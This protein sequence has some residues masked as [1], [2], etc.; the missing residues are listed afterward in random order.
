MRQLHELRPVI[1]RYARD[2]C[3]RLDYNHDYEHH[4][5]FV[6]RDAEYIAEEERADRDVVW[7]AAMLHEIGLVQGRSGHD[8]R[9]ARLAQEY[10]RG[11]G[12]ADT[13]V[14]RISIAIRENTHDRVAA[15]TLETKCL[16]D[17]DNLQTIGP[18]GFVRVLSDLL[19]VLQKLPRHE[20]M[21][22]LPKY[23]ER[24]MGRL[25]TKTGR[26]LAEQGHRLMQEFYG[27][28]EAFY[29]HV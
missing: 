9:G 28:Y 11:L 23:Q 8:E 17:A 1:Q 10:L 18:V 12:V 13:A 21:A 24:Q 19:V 3:G 22:E 25:Q 4:I 6:A 20:A 26:A 16:Y 7:T 14:D 5:V 15:S 29:S 27:Q 2:A